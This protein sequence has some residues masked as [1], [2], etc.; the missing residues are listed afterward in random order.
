MDQSYRRRKGHAPFGIHAFRWWPTSLCRP[1][2]CLHGS[3]HDHGVLDS[4]IPIQWYPFTA[5]DQVPFRVVNYHEIQTRFQNPHPKAPLID[6]KIVHVC[7]FIPI[8]VILNQHLHYYL[9]WLYFAG[10]LLYLSRT[11][12]KEHVNVL[13]FNRHCS[14]TTYLVSFV[15]RLRSDHGKH[16]CVMSDV[17]G[18]LF[19]KFVI[20]LVGLS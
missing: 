16:L 18:M 10:L 14:G 19:G 7:S 15:T 20:I 8:Q 13:T 4:R 12:W 17:I 9:D 3:S 1:T 11:E 6:Y 5:R 2:L